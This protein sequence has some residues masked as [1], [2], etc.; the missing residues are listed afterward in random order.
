[1][2]Q[3]LKLPEATA[4]RI[5][6]MHDQALQ[7]QT[8]YQQQMNAVQQAVFVAAECSGITDPEPQYDKAAGE[9]IYKTEGD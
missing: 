6:D 5:K 8:A 1:M 4:K 2:E 9:I 7:L 3:R